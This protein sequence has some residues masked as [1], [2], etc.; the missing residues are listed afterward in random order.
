MPTCRPSWPAPLHDRARRHHRLLQGQSA[1]APSCCEVFEPGVR[2][3]G[4]KNKNYW[5][6]GRPDL[7]DLRVLRDLRR[8]P[9][10]STRCSPATSSSPRR[11]IRAPCGS[12]ERARL[13]SCR[14]P[15]RATT[16]TSTC[17]STWRRATRPTS[18]QGMKYLSTAS[19]S[20]IR[21]CAALPK[22]ANDQPVP[23]M[24]PLTT[25]PTC[26]RSAF[27]PEKAKAHLPE[28]GSARPADPGRRLRR[29]A[30]PRSTWR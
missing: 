23:P 19:R 15:T 8:R 10:A 3:I 9:P 6:P 11:S 18:S 16:P 7:D 2:S 26:S 28:G 27:D 1:P 5:K 25:T 17:A 22:S 13:R 30:P 20:K 21:R 4:V 12:S 29:R 14:R 24:Q